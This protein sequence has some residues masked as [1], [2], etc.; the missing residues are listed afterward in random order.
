M[1]ARRSTIMPRAPVGR[2]LA[3][4]GAR[5]S[6]DAAKALAN[7]LEEKAME[8]GE[9]AVKVAKHAGRKTVQDGDIRLAARK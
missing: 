4:T 3:R 1:G 8:I 2:I 9:H 7:Y 6:A 5:V